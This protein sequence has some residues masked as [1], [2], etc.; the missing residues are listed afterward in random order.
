MFLWD[1]VLLNAEESTV[2]HYVAGCTAKCGFLSSDP[3]INFFSSQDNVFPVSR[4]LAFSEYV[5][6]SSG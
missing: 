5:R 3:N 4:T 6:I 2:L 1:L